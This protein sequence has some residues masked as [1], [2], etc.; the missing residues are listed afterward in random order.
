MCSSA[1]AMSVA[2]NAPSSFQAPCSRVETVKIRCGTIPAF[3]QISVGKPH[4]ITPVGRGFVVGDRVDEGHR[5]AERSEPAV[6]IEL[7]VGELAR[8]ERQDF[9]GA[10]GGRAHDLFG[11]RKSPNRTAARERARVRA[12]NPRASR[13]GTACASRPRACRRPGSRPTRHRRRAR[14]SWVRHRTEREPES[15]TRR[16]SPRRA[17][18]ACRRAR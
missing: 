6:E 15:A 14:T 5:L 12:A 18:R 11:Q 8:E 7:A 13:P 17:A 2:R 1:W 10:A 9:A 4:D 16:R 3:A